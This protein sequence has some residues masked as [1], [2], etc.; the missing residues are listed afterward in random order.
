MTSF[1]QPPSRHIAWEQLQERLKEGVPFVHRVSAPNPSR[2]SVDIRVSE[3]G[4][5]L[6]LWVPCAVPEQK[7][8]SPLIEI[9]FS[10]ILTERGPMIEIKTR[11]PILFQEI[12]SFFVSVIDK[13]QLDNANP[14]AAINETLEGWRE[15]LKTRA[16]LSEEA[17]LGLRGE[18]HLLR[19]LV[20]VIG[21]EALAAWTGPQN[22]PHD[23]RIRDLELEV[24]TTC[25]A[26]HAHII[27]GL[28]QM[29][30]SPGHR[31]YVFSLRMAPA[32]AMAG[33]TLPDDIEH[34]RLALG[35]SVQVRFE[36]LIRDRF[37]YRKEHAGFYIR[38]L[39]LADKACLI[40]VDESCPRLSAPL[41][42]SVPHRG[43]ISDVR[44]RINFEGLGFP[45][46]SQE[47][48]AIISGE[49]PQI[50]SD[51]ES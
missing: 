27:N 4:K 29:E 6:S 34:T 26:V 18:L 50:Q 47:F 21:D 7:I 28:G 48:Q 14:F 51:R 41:L 19:M 36:H 15:L 13:I 30:P 31:L 33:T 45:E 24:K 10:L 25:G 22:Q 35:L 3:N 12:Y 37:G 2:L 20:G 1:T 39:Q 42:A 8:D 44:Y 11:L 9:A 43:L 46:G 16:I 38:R 32:G 5:E 17:Q 40:P 23:F 49:C